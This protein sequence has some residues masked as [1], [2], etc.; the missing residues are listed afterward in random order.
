MSMGRRGPGG[1]GVSPH[2]NLSDMMCH[3]LGFP[4][5]EVDTTGVLPI[6]KK[7]KTTSIGA[8]RPLVSTWASLGG[9][10][11]IE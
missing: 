8:G 10:L 5:Q 9:A 3:A 1:L 11:P 2:K 7:L 4:H 6:N